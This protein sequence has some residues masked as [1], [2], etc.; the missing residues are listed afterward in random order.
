MLR[1][2]QEAA[3][4]R[5]ADIAQ[6]HLEGMKITS[7]NRLCRQAVSYRVEI[8]SRRNTMS[9]TAT[10]QFATL[11]AACRRPREIE[12]A[13][14]RQT[15]WPPPG[16]VRSR[17]HAHFSHFSPPPFGVLEKPRA[18]HGRMEPP[19]LPSLSQ[20]S[21]KMVIGDGIV[22]GHLRANSRQSGR[23]SPPQPKYWD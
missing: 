22:G 17:V 4:E 7:W 9:K 15:F 20:R 16:E 8:S 10:F 2:E 14:D 1:E 11:F 3:G 5:A 23:S 13:T 21:D 6:R 19:S 18:A 12:Y